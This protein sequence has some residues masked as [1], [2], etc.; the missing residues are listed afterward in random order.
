MKERIGTKMNNFGDKFSAKYP[1]VADKTGKAFGYIRDVWQETFPNQ[2]AH[3]KSRLERR[4]EIAQMQQKYSE[5]E[6]HQMEEEIPEW[7]RGAVE[8]TDTEVEDSDSF[9]KK[10]GR[11]VG[12]K[13][14]ETEYAQNFYESEDYK[15]LEALR[16]NI[17]EFKHEVQDEMDTTQNPMLQRSRE[18]IDLVFIESSCGQAIKEM[19]KF[20]PEFDINDLPIEAKE[21]FKEFF[22]NFL[23]GNLEYLEKVSAQQALAVSKG[24]MKIRKTEGWKYRYHDIL[25]VGESQLL[26]GTIP[27]K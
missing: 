3:V 12:S 1:R 23:A 11:T 4:R 8:V 26:G 6:L 19:Q 16:A 27:E 5:E 21:V 14:N 22:C 15:E 13:I 9:F 10:L 7:K 18:V 2:D 24:D 17:R 25:D 20:D